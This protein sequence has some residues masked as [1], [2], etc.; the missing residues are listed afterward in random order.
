MYTPVEHQHKL[1]QGTPVACVHVQNN[2]ESMNYESLFDLLLPS[3]YA[4]SDNLTDFP[5]FRIWIYD[6]QGT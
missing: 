5:L 4:A 6:A 3:G 2:L 1:W